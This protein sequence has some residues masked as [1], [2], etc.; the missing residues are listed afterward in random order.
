MN[1]EQIYYKL[2]T[3]FRASTDLGNDLNVVDLALIAIHQAN[4]DIKQLPYPLK[5]D[6]YEDLKKRFLPMLVT[7]GIV[8]SFE[9]TYDG[10]GFWITPSYDRRRDDKTFQILKVFDKIELG[11]VFA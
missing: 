10:T 4:I 5:Q 3:L 1:K 7:E 8:K 6:L 9:P 11:P 2:L